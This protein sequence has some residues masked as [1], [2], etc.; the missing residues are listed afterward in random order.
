MTTDIIAETDGHCVILDDRQTRLLA[1]EMIARRLCDP[2]EWAC[3]E[4]VPLLDEEG[5]E[6]L[7]EAIGNATA[8][9]LADDA[10]ALGVW[11]SVQ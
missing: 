11:G 7:I 2:E 1:Q 10:E 9:L 3:W 4:L 5:H 8:D 6:R